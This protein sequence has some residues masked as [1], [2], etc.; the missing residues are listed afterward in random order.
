MDNKRVIA[1]FDFDDTITTEKTLYDFIA[2]YHGKI[3]LRLGLVLLSPVLLLE[4]LHLVSK[5]KVKE[6]IIS[7]FLKGEKKEKVDAA[8]ANY[9]IKLIEI[10]NP[11]ALDKIQWHQ[12]KGHTI[13]ID[14]SACE[15]WVKPWAKEAGIN[16]VIATRLETKNGILTGKLAGRDCYGQQKVSRFLELFPKRDSYILYVYGDDKGDKELLAIADHPFY[17]KF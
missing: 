9:S 8:C 14:C 17:R 1:V 4:L 16:N 5:E 13:V 6:I 11:H 2:F 10:L 3:R 12:E 15:D 7:Y